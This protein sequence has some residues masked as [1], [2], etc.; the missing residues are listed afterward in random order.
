MSNGDIIDYDIH[1]ERNGGQD[2]YTH[3]KI[4]DDT[5]E[6]DLEWMGHFSDG[7]LTGSILNYYSD[8]KDSQ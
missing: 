8:W 5:V 1:E 2:G 4:N 6:T 3:L 7:T